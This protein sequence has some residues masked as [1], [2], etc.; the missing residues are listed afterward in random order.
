MINNQIIDAL[1]Y[2]HVGL[3]IHTH[4]ISTGGDTSQT[5]PVVTGFNE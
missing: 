5:I 4:R 1:V 2:S 3:P